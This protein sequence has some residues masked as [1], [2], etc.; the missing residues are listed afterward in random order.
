MPKILWTQPYI[1][2][3]EQADTIKDDKY[4]MY[5]NR[6]DTVGS[7]T[8]QGLRDELVPKSSCQCTC[9]KIGKTTTGKERTVAPCGWSSFHVAVHSVA[10]VMDRQFC[11][12]DMHAG[13]KKD[14][15]SVMEDFSK[16]QGC[17]H[18]SKMKVQYEMFV[19]AVGSNQVTV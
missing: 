1:D 17:K 12:R 4:V 18:F 14:M 13:V 15:W 8:L 11:R 3:I 10:F 5:L 9:P 2:M 19:D 7:P 6:D 16:A